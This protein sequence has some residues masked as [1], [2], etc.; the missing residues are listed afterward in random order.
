M[1]LSECNS[2][3]GYYLVSMTFFSLPFVG[4]LCPWINMSTFFLEAKI[5]IG[6][7]HRAYVVCVE[8]HYTRARA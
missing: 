7:Y 2:L 6:E 8:I 4:T 1:P 3:S 5:K